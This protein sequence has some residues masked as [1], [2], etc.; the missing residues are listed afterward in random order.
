MV[1][2]FVAL[3][4]AY[5][6]CP[7]APNRANARA[8][9]PQPFALLIAHVRQLV[10]HLG[11]ERNRAKCLAGLCERIQA[12]LAAHTLGLALKPLALI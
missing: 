5:R 4:T 6:N 12:T 7:L 8:P 2:D 1:Y 9:M 3:C 10:E 11:I